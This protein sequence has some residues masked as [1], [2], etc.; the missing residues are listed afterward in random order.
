MLILKNQ[1]DE[2]HSLVLPLILN[3]TLH[4]HRRR[5]WPIAWP[6]SGSFLPTRNDVSSY[7]Y[8][9]LCRINQPLVEHQV[10]HWYNPQDSSWYYPHTKVSTCSSL[11]PIFWHL[12]FCSLFPLALL[13]CVTDTSSCVYWRIGAILPPVSSNFSPYP[14]IV[15]KFHIKIRHLVRFHFIFFDLRLACHLTFDFCVCSSLFHPFQFLRVFTF[16]LIYLQV[17]LLAIFG[18]VYILAANKYPLPFLWYRGPLKIS[19]WL[20]FS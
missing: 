20:H 6:P 17:N 18:L 14:C 11:L 13:S 1:L 2:I 19:G 16:W 3:M 12:F 9:V 7:Q 10:Y 4:L 15:G 8:V 5:W